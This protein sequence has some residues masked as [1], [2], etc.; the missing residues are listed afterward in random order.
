MKPL[1]QLTFFL[2]ISIYHLLALLRNLI[3]NNNNNMYILTRFFF[4]DCQICFLTA[5]LFS[6]E[7]STRL[8]YKVYQYTH[9]DTHAHT[10]TH[11]YTHIYIYIYQIRFTNILNLFVSGLSCYVIFFLGVGKKLVQYLESFVNTANI[12]PIFNISAEHSMVFFIFIFL[13]PFS[14]ATDILL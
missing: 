5:L 6:L 11:T 1:M 13:M 14:D 8:L 4:L 2:L 3:N 12:K 7:L 9:A 10:H